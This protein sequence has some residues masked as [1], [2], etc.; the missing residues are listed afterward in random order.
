MLGLMAGEAVAQEGATVEARVTY[1]AGPNVYLD[2]GRD[3]GIEPGDTL[4]VVRE[5]ADVGRLVVVSSIADRSVVTFAAAPFALTRG[6]TLLLRVPRL[7]PEAAPAPEPTPETVDPAPE[8]PP[9]AT[10]PEPPP[11]RTAGV[12]EGPDV[13][14]RLQVGLSALRSATTWQTGDAGTTAR[15]FAT[16]SANLHL[17]VVNLP[18][19]LHLRTRVRAD[20]RY[21]AGRAIDPALSVRTYEMVVAKDFGNVEVQAGRFPNRYAP[22][23]GYWDGALVHVGSARVGAGTAV[24]FMPDRSNEGFS[25]AMP[26]YGGFAHAELGDAERLEY[27][28]SVAFNEIRPTNHLLMHRFASVTQQLRHAGYSLRTDLQVDRDP[29]AGAWT[30]SRFVVRGV[31]VPGPRLSLH[32]RYRLRRP[33]SIWRVTRIISYR[34]DQAT[35]GAALRLDGLTL[36]ADVALNF[37]EDLDGTMTDDGR[38]LSGY[39][40]VPRLGTTGLGLSATASRWQDDDGASLFLNTGLTRSLGRARTRLQY[41]FYRTDVQALPT[42]LMTHAVS[43]YASMPLGRGLSGS[44]QLRLQQGGTLRSASF[45]ISLW[46]GF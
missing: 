30:V 16:P 44:G 5:G 20:Y 35:A 22:F 3:R 34:R 27:E 28:A 8:A 43:A 4:V 41:Q 32:A 10:S 24:G 17:T 9:E 2:A 40:Q 31:A 7:P 45:F 37:A 46:Y 26:R 29:E 13:S 18:A 19:D 39:V 36:G 6:A 42:A 33:Y 15:T 12:R 23:D 21:T 25:A 11:R 38:T 1:L 14:G